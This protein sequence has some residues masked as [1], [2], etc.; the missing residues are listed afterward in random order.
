MVNS[1]F[2]VSR[3]HNVRETVEC[4]EILLGVHL[5]AVSYEAVS[6]EVCRRRAVL[7]K[8]SKQWQISIE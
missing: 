7:T 8:Q 2:N 5:P 4:A 1:H 6:I 3:T